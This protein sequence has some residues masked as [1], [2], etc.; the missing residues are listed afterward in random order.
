ME[1]QVADIIA[2]MQQYQVKVS[3]PMIKVAKDHIEKIKQLE[4][5]NAEQD[6]KGKQIDAAL[7]GIKNLGQ[8]VNDAET[9]TPT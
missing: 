3:N 9:E 5:K 8:S 1:K 7:E 6:A 4:A 2:W